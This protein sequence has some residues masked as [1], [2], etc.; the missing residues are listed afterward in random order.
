[1]DSRAW[2]IVRIVL[3]LP[4]MY[5]SKKYSKSYR[6]LGSS[7]SSASQQNKEKEA[8]NKFKLRKK[9]HHPDLE[10]FSIQNDRLRVLRVLRVLWKRKS[11]RENY[12]LVNSSIFETSS[13]RRTSIF[14]LVLFFYN[15]V[16]GR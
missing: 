5:R 3:V 2:S 14:L 6:I 7:S 13:Q 1:M 12:I 9:D 10:S 15:M 8:Q 4:A 16:P 11:R